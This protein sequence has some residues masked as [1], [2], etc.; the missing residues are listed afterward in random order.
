MPDESSF[1]DPLHLSWEGSQQFSRRLGKFYAD[2]SAAP[3]YSEP[4]VAGAA[5]SEREAPLPL[6]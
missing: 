3:P 1:A 5:A 2:G 4:G 6:R